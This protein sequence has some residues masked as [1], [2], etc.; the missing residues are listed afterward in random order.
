MQRLYNRQRAYATTKI[1]SNRHQ[2]SKQNNG[3]HQHGNYAHNQLRLQ[4]FLIFL[5]PARYLNSGTALQIVDIQVLMTPYQ[6]Q[7]S[8]STLYTHKTVF[9]SPY[10]AHH[11][12]FTITSLSL[13]AC[14]LLFIL[15]SFFVS[16]N[17]FTL[18]RSYTSCVIYYIVLCIY[19]LSVQYTYAFNSVKFEPFT[20]HLNYE[21]H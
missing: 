11:L 7:Y 3:A 12:L 1:Q 18:T 9:V 10:T 2:Y 4:G 5:K 6:L 14:R 13:T 15:F 17:N 21:I 8:A 19:I 20:L 16:C